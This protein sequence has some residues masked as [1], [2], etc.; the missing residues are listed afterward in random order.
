MKRVAQAGGTTAQIQS[1]A[2]KAKQLVVNTEDWSLYVMDGT[3]NGGHRLSLK[4]EVDQGLSGKAASSHTHSTSQVTGLDTAL[5]GKIPISGARGSLAG[6]E[7]LASQSSAVTITNE[8]ADDMVVTAAVQITVQDG[9][10][11]QTWEKT[12]AITNASATVQLGSK[13]KWQ[14][15][16]APE[17]SA[18][19]LLIL[20]WCGTFGFAS[21]QATE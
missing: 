8:S 3:N 12:V 19:S 11:G 13:W 6:Y 15:G 16:S 21:L 2:G 5:S 1:Y 18:N 14:G 9:A 7:T 20:K 10:S 17:V 4:A